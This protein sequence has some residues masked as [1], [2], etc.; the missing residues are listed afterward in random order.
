MVLKIN[1]YNMLVFN[2]MKLLKYAKQYLFFSNMFTKFAFLKITSEN[3][4]VAGK[5]T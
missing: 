1:F 3:Y 4:I 2:P 5:F